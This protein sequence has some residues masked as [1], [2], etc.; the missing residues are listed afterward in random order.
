MQKNVFA[1]A[2]LLYMDTFFRVY[3][4]LFRHPMSKNDVISKHLFCFSYGVNVEPTVDISAPLISDQ[5]V[6]KLRKHLMSYSWNA[7]QVSIGVL[8]G[9]FSSS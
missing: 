3:V 6:G 9:F 4:M 7:I 8:S 1:P 5:D 2:L